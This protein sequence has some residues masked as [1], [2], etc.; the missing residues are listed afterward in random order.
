M[1]GLLRDGAFTIGVAGAL[2]FGAT[3]AF[4]ARSAL[5]P[6]CPDEY[7]WC[8][9]SVS[10]DPD[11]NCTEC[12]DETTNGQLPNGTCLSYAESSGQGCFCWAP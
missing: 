2:L 1:K 12:C 11:V 3:E 6:N 7:N 5:D 10:P 8:A 9:P 4:A